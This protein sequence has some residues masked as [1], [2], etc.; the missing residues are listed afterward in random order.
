MHANET[1]TQLNKK[2]KEKKRKLEELWSKKRQNAE[3][4]K[5]IVEEHKTLEQLKAKQRPF[6][7]VGC[8]GTSKKIVDKKGSF[9]YMNLECQT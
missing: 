5:V 6:I 1:S 8:M 2:Q 4:E 9:V 3:V 7:A